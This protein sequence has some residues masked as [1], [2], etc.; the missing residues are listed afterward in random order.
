M[1]MRLF[2]FYDHLSTPIGNAVGANA[3]CMNEYGS[4][5]KRFSPQADANPWSRM[6]EPKCFPPS[7]PHQATELDAKDT[8]TELVFTTITC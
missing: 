7:L 4:L 1:R 5:L 3:E 8:G 2:E 6:M